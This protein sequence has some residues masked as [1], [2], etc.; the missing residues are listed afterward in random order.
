V[1]EGTFLTRTKGFSGI[2]KIIIEIGNGP[3]MCA[4]AKSLIIG[5]L[6]ALEEYDRIHVM[7]ISACRRNDSEAV[8]GY[9]SLLEDAKFKMHSARKQFQEHQNTHNCSE[10]IRFDIDLKRNA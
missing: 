10:V 8:E 4:E 2:G 5:Y 9:G 6:D 1:W 7:Y 3:A